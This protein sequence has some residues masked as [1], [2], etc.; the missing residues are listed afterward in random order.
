M[1]RIEGVVVVDDP[2]IIPYAE[3][4]EELA[5]GQRLPSI[6]SLE[7]AEAGDLMA[8]AVDFIEMYRHAPVFVDKILK[9]AKPYELPVE[10]PTNFKF[11]INLK[12]ANA[13]GLKIAN[14]LFARADEV[15]E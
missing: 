10:Q 4:L 5:T 15:I 14:L 8:Y 3:S 12:T 11:V 13:L 1:R 6:G 7:I 2:A 9:G